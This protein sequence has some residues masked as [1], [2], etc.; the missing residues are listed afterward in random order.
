MGKNEGGVKEEREVEPE[1]EVQ[2]AAVQVD[3]A[4]QGAS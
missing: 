1:A 4:E 2:T 3:S